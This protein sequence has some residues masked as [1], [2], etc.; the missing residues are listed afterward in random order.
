PYFGSTIK[1]NNDY[2]ICGM[3]NG[4]DLVFYYD[5][6]PGEGLMFLH[7]YDNYYNRVSLRWGGAC[8][9]ENE[10]VC[11]A[12]IQDNPLEWVNETGEIQRV[13][14]VEG[15]S[16]DSGKFA[17]Y[18]K[19]LA[20][21][22][23][24]TPN[25][26]VELHTD[27]SV[28]LSWS[29][30]AGVEEWEVRY[31]SQGFDMEVDGSLLIVT[32][33]SVVLNGLQHSTSYDYYVRA[34]CSADDKSS[35]ASSS[36][37]T[38]CGNIS[39]PFNVDFENQQDLS[40]WKLL[41]IEGWANSYISSGSVYYSMDPGNILLHVLPEISEIAKNTL[42]RVRPST[43]YFGSGVMEIGT[44]SAFNDYT[45]FVAAASFQISSLDE[46]VHEFGAILDE[47]PE[48]HSYIGIRVV[49]TGTDRFQLGFDALEVELLN[50][51]MVPTNFRVDELASRSA[52]FSW[53]ELGLADEWELSWDGVDGINE[54]ELRY[55]NLGSEEAIIVTVTGDAQ[56]LLEQLDPEVYYEVDV[57]AVC[58][59]D[60]MSWS[61]SGATIP[62]LCAG[63]IT[64][65]FSE[66][67]AGL[68]N[69]SFPVCWES[70][71]SPKAT[72]ELMVTNTRDL[73]EYLYF[74]LTSS[75]SAITAI[76]PEM[77]QSIS[78]VRVSF[79]TYKPSWNGNQAKLQ[80][81]VLGENGFVEVETIVLEISP[82]LAWK[83]HRVY[84][85]NSGLTEGRLAF[86]LITGEYE[87]YRT[88]YLSDIKVEMIP[89]VTDPHALSMND[90]N[91]T[92][93]ELSWSQFE[94]ADKVDLVWGNVGFNPDSEGQN[95]VLPAE[96]LK[97]QVSDLSPN[98]SYEAYVRNVSNQEGASQWAGP[99]EFHTPC[100]PMQIN[101]LNVEENEVLYAG[102]DN[103]VRLAYNYLCYK[104]ET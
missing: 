38:E 57:R 91:Q 22:Y 8:P 94:T 77:T 48:G 53:Q 25:D 68:P 37:S 100:A 28:K 87:S 93:G 82:R 74:N 104:N 46:K 88:F 98:T 43:T 97:C 24:L 59:G 50:D 7:L 42:V 66:S 101:L 18:W 58:A 83:D 47:W 85:N 86:R 4:N 6:E 9:G 23:C 81:G 96:A 36:F 72:G 21:G 5:V 92:S 90:L 3:G 14:L 63:P 39:L 16:Y 99:L 56:H 80:V 76:L 17:L 67:F 11:G 29:N 26:L 44:L 79:K 45:T 78:N 60:G 84:F 62:I 10:I 65:P 40:C 71:W 30:S 20:P 2:S 51:C 64:L 102:E 35:W 70:V 103:V 27:G 89:D 12:D 34:I 55:R 19:S 32:E 13:W 31:G 49:N 69:N 1:A 33:P 73:G 61:S 52:I 54:W 41:N 75:E 15:S 95:R